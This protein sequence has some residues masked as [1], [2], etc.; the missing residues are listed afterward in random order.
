[1]RSYDLVAY[2]VT[3]VIF[4]DKENPGVIVKC[5]N[6]Q[7]FYDLD[8]VKKL[9]A[10]EQRNAYEL[11]NNISNPKVS[12]AI[13]FQLDQYEDEL[14]VLQMLKGKK[15]IIQIIGD[16]VEDNGLVVGIKMERMSTDLYHWLRKR[17]VIDY[18]LTMLL[19]SQLLNGIKSIHDIF[20][21][22]L[23]I[24]PSNLLINDNNELKIADFGNAL[25]V[26][27]EGFDHVTLNYRPPELFENEKYKTFEEV[28]KAD[29][30]SAGCVIYEIYYL[31]ENLFPPKYNKDEFRMII[32]LMKQTTDIPLIHILVSR[33]VC[34]LKD[35]ENIYNIIELFN[36][37]NED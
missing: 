8:D 37:L 9:T 11:V 20:Y 12:D 4:G 22:H 5:F 26:M 31:G 36:H 10:K 7:V 34:L 28:M 13:R 30:W 33:M 25:S 14:E 21:A 2:G 3:G 35:R 24:K 23:D 19:T 29:I 27:P 16:G 6:Y 18:R 1:M 15:N 17:E 32:G